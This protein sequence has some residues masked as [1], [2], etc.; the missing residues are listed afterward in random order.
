[1]TEVQRVLENLIKEGLPEPK[2]PN[3]S[4]VPMTEGVSGKNV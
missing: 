3:E 4:K 2:A 1:M